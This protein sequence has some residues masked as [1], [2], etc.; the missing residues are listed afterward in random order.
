MHR[1]KREEQYYS[2]VVTIADVEAQNWNLSV[3]TYV[4]KA[5]TSERIDIAELN[6]RIAG[7]VERQAKLREEI[8]KIVEELEA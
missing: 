4:E 6:A 3:S 8:D 1:L 2:H 5:D 7:I